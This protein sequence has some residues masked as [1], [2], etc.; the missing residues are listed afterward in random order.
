M[1]PLDQLSGQ[2]VALTQRL[3]LY[4]DT[5]AVLIPA[6]GNTS[7]FV[8]L[9]FPL[10]GQQA[11]RIVSANAVVFDV[12]A[13]YKIVPQSLSFQLISP[14]GKYVDL[15]P[16]PATMGLALG[17]DGVCIA[18]RQKDLLLWNDYASQGGLVGTLQLALNA[19][20]IN[21]DGSNAHSYW[22][23]ANAIV[24]LYAVSTSGLTGQ[25]AIG[26]KP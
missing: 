5:G 2:Y 12:D 11:F 25:E 21:T 6:G 4:A 24:E 14:Y 3:S 17:S 19:D 15:Y 7:I 13:N 1:P 8:P 26:Y 10:A 20:L 23:I 18:S 16:S 9:K 22:A